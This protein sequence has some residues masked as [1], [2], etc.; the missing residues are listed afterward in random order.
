MHC[1]ITDVSKYWW[2][3][4]WADA[5]GTPASSHLT[6]RQFFSLSLHLM[7]MS[8]PGHTDGVRRSISSIF[9]GI[10]YSIS[11]RET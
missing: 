7:L 9:S 1:N 5:H 6:P 10:I 2:V 11:S 8:I 3:C 4:L